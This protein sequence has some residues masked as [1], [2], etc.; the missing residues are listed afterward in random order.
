L[1]FYTQSDYLKEFRGHGKGP[2]Y[3]APAIWI[4]DEDILDV[5]EA[6]RIWNAKLLEPVRFLFAGRLV[7]EKGVR[8]LLTAVDKV[9]AT[10]ARGEIHFIGDGPLRQAVVAAQ[11]SESFGLKYFEPLPYGSQ[12]MTFLQ[13]YH[14]IVVPSLGDEQPRI[15]FD[16][17]ARAVPIVASATN[18]LRPHIEHQRTGIL[19]PAGD[20]SAL[21]AVLD[22]LTK[23]PVCLRDFAMEALSRAQNRTHRSMHAERS[24]LIALHLGA[25][26]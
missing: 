25:G 26:R 13:N 7:E 10:G 15:I 2:A 4:N 18:G 23:D 16:A 8:I 24:R 20:A 9:T 22:S 5:A 14:A 21:A 3:V 11:R 1:S 19:I 12:F 17:A 6:R